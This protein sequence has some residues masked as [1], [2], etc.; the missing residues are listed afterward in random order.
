MQ[1]LFIDTTWDVLCVSFAHQGEVLSCVHQSAKGAHTRFLAQAVFSC[2]KE[3]RVSL[4][5][6]EAIA[7]MTGPGSFTGIRSGLSFAYGL[8]QGLEVPLIGITTLEAILLCNQGCDMAL[9]DA[10]NDKAYVQFS[11]DQKAKLLD[12]EACKACLV[13]AK[14]PSFLAPFTQTSAQLE[15]ALTTQGATATQALAPKALM[16]YFTKRLERLREEAGS[17]SVAFA[18]MQTKN[19]WPQAN[20]MT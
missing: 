12:F 2:A 8:A 4:P 20:Y 5:D 14:H 11:L 19:A 9:V 17:A 16:S 1:L 15:H 7:I 13:C 18:Q 3:S 6:L 10:R